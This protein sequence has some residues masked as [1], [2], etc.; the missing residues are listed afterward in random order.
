[1][2]ELIK[3]RWFVFLLGILIAVIA[4]LIFGLILYCNGY[5][6]VY[7]EQFETSWDAVS[8]FAAWFG[9][10]VSIVSVG[11]SLAAV[12]AAIQVPKKIAEQQEKVELYEKRLDFYNTIDACI[13][14]AYTIESLLPDTAIK[15]LFVVTFENETKPSRSKEEIDREAIFLFCRV[16]E[17][18]KHGEFLF[19]CD[20]KKYTKV[21]VETL[22]NLLTLESLEVDNRKDRVTK[23]VIAVKNA[24]EN[25]LP[26]VKD[27]LTLWS[28]K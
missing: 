10:A 5:R 14:F 4:L 13:R 15:Y 21:I 19:E 1:M 27:S 20:V 23:Y 25:L 17:S 3:K 2:K 22:T 26:F 12:W 16:V 6:I 9:V 11:A 7:P 24:Q 18:L 8:G 28:N